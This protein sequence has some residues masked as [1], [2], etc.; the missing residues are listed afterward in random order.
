M[1]DLK[2]ISMN[3]RA[4]A[5]RYLRPLWPQVS[6]L[7][8]LLIAST[9]LQVWA[10]QVIRDFIDAAVNGS[11]FAVL[12]RLALLYTA[13]AIGHHLTG[14]WGKYLG[15]DVGW[16]ATNSLRAGLIDHC[17]SLGPSFCKTH[18]PGELVERIDGD[19]AN[20]AGIFS[21]LIAGVVANALY[22]AMALVV[23]FRTNLLAGA[24]VFLSSGFA[25]FVLLRMRKAASPLW[26]KVRESMAHFYGC[27]SEWIEG[28]EDVKTCG[29]SGWVLRRLHENARLWYP[30]HC[31]AMGARFRTAAAGVFLFSTGTAA[32][33]AVA[34]AL[35]LKGRITL[36]TAFAIFTYAEMVRRPLE[37]LEVNLRGMQSAGGSLSRVS[38]L[39]SNKPTVSDSHV[40][41]SSPTLESG[42]Q[43][44]EF[45]GVTFS[46]EDGGE[47]VLDNVNFRVEPGR[48]LGV[49]GRTGAGKTTIARLLFRFYDPDS[50]EIRMGGR[51]IRGFRLTDLRRRVAFV[52]QD[53]QILKTSLRD[54]LA[55]FDRN[56][57]DERLRLALNEVGLGE[58]L[59]ALPEGLSTVIGPGGRDLSAGEAQLVAFARLSLRDPAV[60]ILDEAS[61]RL[62][63]ATESSLE[64]AVSACLRGRT[65]VI[66]AHRLATLDRTDDI[67]ILEGGRVVEHGRREDLA[68]DPS[69]RYS[70]L[71]RTG[72][73]E[74]LK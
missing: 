29:A 59:A 20:L 57:P 73:E 42:P 61:S 25:L 26:A 45:V 54:N 33:L 24:T 60:V 4:L 72:I 68:S 16:R 23:L 12:E 55:F 13:L 28:M 32:A 65:G 46:Y 9:G 40:G 66:I 15:D 49:L 48:V 21:R 27:L 7:A 63:P 50:G 52:T 39:L 51:D 6:L 8:V 10:P 3:Q 37:Q 71:L 47:V 34:V 5:A 35:Y 62:D 44:V 36:G 56:I 18:S 53:V 74:V 22:L 31:R 58:W 1:T 43:S 38:E 70:R 14:A 30:W 64:A 2:E 17:L 41:E 19:S 67:L 11:G 69:S